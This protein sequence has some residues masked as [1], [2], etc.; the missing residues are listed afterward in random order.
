MV[1]ILR[2]IPLRVS[3]HTLFLER[4]VEL[5]PDN[6]N[7][8]TM[9][10]VDSTTPVPLKSTRFFYIQQKTLEDTRFPFHSNIVSHLYKRHV[11]NHI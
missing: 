6:F 1:G 7:P 5:G 10:P 8:N 4:F 2:R 3:H 9:K 11:P